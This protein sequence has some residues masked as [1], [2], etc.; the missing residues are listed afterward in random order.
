M[1]PKL[2]RQLER[3]AAALDEG[4]ID[5]GHAE[6]LAF[7]ALLREGIP[8]RLTGQDTERG[9]FSHRHLVFH[10]SETGEIEIPMQRLDG[11]KASF[12]VYNSPLS[13][14]ACVG[15]EYGYSTAAP[16]A[17]V[18]W[19][20]QFG[21]FANG[22]QTIIDQFISSGLAKWKQTSRL[23][24]LLPH[25]YEGNGPEHSSARLERFL[26][27]TAQENLRICNPTTS[28]QYFHLLRRQALDPI[29]RPLVVMT[30]KGL[31]RLKNASST[32]AELSEGSFR[33][34]IDASVADRSH[35]RR[36]VICS[37]KVYYDITGHELAGEA[38]EIAVARLEQLYP[39]PVAAARGL[40]AALSE[41]RRDRVGAGG[42]AEHG[43]VAHDPPPAR[44][45]GRRC[46]GPLRR[47]ALAR[48]HRRGLPDGA[49]ARAGADRARRPD[50]LDASSG[51]G[52][53][54]RAVR[55]RARACARAR[56]ADDAR[57]AAA[58]TRC[59]RGSR[60][61]AASANGGVQASGLRFCASLGLCRKA[62]ARKRD[63]DQALDLRLRM[64]YDQEDGMAVDTA[65][66]FASV[67]Q[68]HLELRRRNAALEHEMPLERYMPD[69]PFENHPLFK[70]EEQARIEDTMDG[71]QSI[72]DEPTSLD[73]GSA[74]T[75]FPEA[76]RS[77]CRHLHPP[78]PLRLLPT[79]RPHRDAAPAADAPSA[80]EPP[81][82][83]SVEAT[84]EGLW[85]RSRDFDWGD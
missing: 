80:E 9:T 33:P 11:A 57:T 76:P 2:A 45:G 37:G 51:A 6:A 73:W 70:T 59:S 47:Q 29:A 85:S 43:G 62:L 19:E 74:D 72:V 75:V 54:T 40:V 21:D 22:A 78:P 26:Q 4:G 79:P 48:Q 27:L 41:A 7:G 1:N 34:T 31:L 24:L 82:E 69:D 50:D 46:P 81:A 30:P 20:A 77:S 3:R 55:A 28:A 23:T 68:E 60:A 83:E 36:L 35:I 84:D 71:N 67:I 61:A 13:E 53:G 44:G 66:L 63:G 18:L 52:G 49:H 12:E 16:E 65:S 56:E 58:A 32:L 10:D 25:G 17:L 15:F 42:A 5:W 39:F 14:Y 8:I 38:N 64:A